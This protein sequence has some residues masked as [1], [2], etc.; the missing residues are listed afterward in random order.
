MVH[1]SYPY[2]RLDQILR[3]LFLVFMEI[4]WLVRILLRILNI[5]LVGALIFLMAAI[6]L[7]SSDVRLPC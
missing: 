5:F 6:H 4:F 3:G 2:K 7:Q 1:G